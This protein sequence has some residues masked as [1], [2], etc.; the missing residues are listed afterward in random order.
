MSMKKGITICFLLIIVFHAD[1]QYGPVPQLGADQFN[2][3]ISQNSGILLDVRTRSEFK[4]G[5]LDKAGNLNYYALDFRKKLKLIPRNQPI[6]LYCNTGYRSEKATEILI[7]NGYANVYNL[8]HGIME[9]ELRNLPLVVEPDAQPD[10]D[11]KM[12]P[13]QYQNILSQGSPVF[14]DFYAPWCG[15]CRKMMP[16]I[17]SLMV[18][19]YPRI[20]M[21]KIN[22]DASKKL[23]K[24][25]KLIGVPYL[26]LHEN[27]KLQFSKNGTASRN[28]LVTVF[29][30]TLLNFSQSLLVED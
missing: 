5:H 22:V 13:E 6:Y 21:F 12:T 9:W 10:R 26:V 4:N 23:V 27:G 18:E 7:E 29:D 15:P 3:L 19:Y 28:E 20:R 16:M 1:G 14:F 2:V 17:D 30:Q 8:Q 24:E 11:N 25:L